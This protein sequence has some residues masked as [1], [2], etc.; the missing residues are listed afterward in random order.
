[1]FSACKLQ[2]VVLIYILQKGTEVSE[3]QEYNVSFVT[4]LFFESCFIFNNF[5]HVERKYVKFY[6]YYNMVGVAAKSKA[7]I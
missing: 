2:V 4:L 5:Y 1:M 7:K 3:Q 6:Y